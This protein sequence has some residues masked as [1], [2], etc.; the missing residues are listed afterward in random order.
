MRLYKLI[1]LEIQAL[2]AEHD[3]TM[4]NIYRYEDILDSRSSMTQVIIKELEDFKKEYGRA[5]RTAIENAAEA[6]Y[7]EK[8]PEEMEGIMTV[9]IGKATEQFENLP[10]VQDANLIRNILY[11]GVWQHYYAMIHGKEKK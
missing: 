4:A 1:G 8:K 7:E 6:V 2:I 3:Q 10:I 5:R 11:G 9:A